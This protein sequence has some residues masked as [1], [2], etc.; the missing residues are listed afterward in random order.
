MSEITH[1]NSESIIVRVS[2]QGQF[3]VNKE[4]MNKINEIDNEIVDMIEN[5]NSSSSSSSSRNKTQQEKEFRGK[6]DQLVKLITVEGKR[7]DDKEIKQSN[8]IVPDPDISIEQAK[9]IFKDE[10]IIPDI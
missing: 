8:I 9:K 2:G 1:D 10:G 4:T 7:L 6:M 3:K 5:S